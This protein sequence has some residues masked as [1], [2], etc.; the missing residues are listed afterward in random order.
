MRLFLS[1]EGFLGLRQIP[2]AERKSFIQALQPLLSHSEGQKSPLQPIKSGDSHLFS[3]DL[4]ERTQALFRQFL[5][6][7]HAQ[8]AWVLM[9]ICPKEELGEIAKRLR[10]FWDG[11]T[12]GLIR[13]Q[14]D[15][16]ELMG[17]PFLRFC[18]RELI[19]WGVPNSI[20]EKVHQVKN[21]EELSSLEGDLQ[22]RVYFH[23]LETAE[24]YLKYG[25]DL[26]NQFLEP[27]Y[28]IEE[29]TVPMAF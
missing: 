6:S 11:E 18:K 15:S 27:Q 24:N 4:D 26:K 13:V 9:A 23:L 10:F 14:P 28:Q 7:S 12:T 19:G 29:M 2:L 22:P 25:R 20:L 3:L 1:Q 8:G 16:Q 21:L 17:P 5:D